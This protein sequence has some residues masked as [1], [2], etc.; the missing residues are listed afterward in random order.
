[1]AVLDGNLVYESLYNNDNQAIPELE[2]VI[3][4]ILAIWNNSVTR[5]IDGRQ[6]HY[7]VVTKWDRFED[8]D[9]TLCQVRDMILEI[10]TIQSYIGRL[11]EESVIRIIPVSAVGK[12]FAEPIAGTREMK[13]VAKRP[14][15]PIN[16]DIPIACL[17]PD[18]VNAE[19]ARS[20]KEL[21][22][23]AHRE[24]L[25]K[26][27]WWKRLAKFVG[28]AID[29]SPTLR[30]LIN[31]FGINQHE[32]ERI[33]TAL[34]DPMLKSEQERDM[35]IAQLAAQANSTNEAAAIVHNH[36][37]TIRG[38]FESKYPSSLVRG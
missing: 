10:P 34:K 33:S 37:E 28:D 29:R 1:M 5:K 6:N 20:L 31:D 38:R 11:D 18:L 27:S 8:S 30:R 7:F 23:A 17:L 15:P 19:I 16:V 2:S 9:E 26:I 4:A 13:I 12:G 32:I 36:F 25:R 3:D 24:A 35:K 14:L 21:E 22:K